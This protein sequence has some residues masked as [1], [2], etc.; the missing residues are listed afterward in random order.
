MNETGSTQPEYSRAGRQHELVTRSV[1]EPPLSHFEAASTGSSPGG[2]ARRQL[3]N[4]PSA[5]AAAT[6]TRRGVLAS[7]LP[8]MVLEITATEPKTPLRAIQ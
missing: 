6:R 8:E 3:V 7:R 2:G 4:G 5:V 1:T